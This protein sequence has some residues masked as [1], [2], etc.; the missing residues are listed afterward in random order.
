MLRFIA[1]VLALCFVATVMS[2]TN[3]EAHYKKH[4]HTKHHHTKH[5][6]KYDK[7][8]HHKWKRHFFR[9]WHRRASCAYAQKYRLQ[10]I[11][12]SDN[13]SSFQDPN[14]LE[15]KILGYSTIVDG[16][17][18]LA[19][20]E[21]I[22]SMH[23]TAGD[24]TLPGPFYQ[25]S[26]EVEEFGQVG[27]GDIAMFGAMGLKANG[28][29]NHEFDGGINQFAHMLAAAQYPFVTVNLDFSNV[30]LEDGTPA[31]RT[32]RDAR[33]CD[34]NSA[35]I[36]K[37]CWLKMGHSKVGLIGRAPADFFN[38]IADPV[39]TLPGLDFVGGRNPDTNQP[40]VSAVGQVLEQVRKLERQGIKRIILL[41]HAQDFTNDPLST[42]AL[43]GIDIIVAAG[44]TG[45]YANEPAHGP[46]NFLRPEDARTPE[47]PPY[48]VMREDSEGK[49]VLVINTEQLYRYVGHLIVTFDRRG[50]ISAIDEDR[51]GPV[52]TTPQAAGLLELEVH[53]SVN[54]EPRV[55]EV[56]EKL[57]QTPT[58]Q[59]AFEFVGT[60]AYELNGQRVDV[61][62]RETNL[63]R[64][65]ADSTL[66]YTRQTFP[67]L[68]V[69]V[70]LKNGGGIRDTILGPNIIR[71]TIQ[72]ALA[73][74]N[75]LTF[76]RMTGGQVLAA[77]ENSVSRVPAADGRFPQIAGMTLRYD[78]SFPGIEGQPSLTAASRV[79][80]LTVT[81][82]NGDVVA[83]VSGG[84]VNAAALSANFVLATNSFTSTGGDGYAA[85]A[86]AT[87]LETTNTGEQQIL[88]AYIQNALG[89]A[90]SLDDPP[91]DPRVED[92]NPQAGL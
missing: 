37:S 40:L 76:L 31:I 89:G 80:D 83:L 16:L 13:E 24:H 28:I 32:G 85:F 64:L 33:P 72:A 27:L 53:R 22:P 38:V 21:C 86:A 39:N 66:W 15:E 68:N 50:V 78:S 23:V 30:V 62:G 36:V 79:R 81:R 14:T 75:D 44:G 42:S 35:K 9:K 29:G 10:V 55:A 56:F 34:F 19:K 90:V 52:A 20:Q 3:A 57:Q 25:A 41:D 67:S 58:I 88:E 7:G 47:D 69:D 71:L 48:P 43:R 92:L 74:D 12:S 77:M 2:P 49:P 4:H 17:Q 6:H 63:G 5:H 51:S 18:K 59:S 26:A 73:F 61:R 84:V 91:A 87:P 1:G 82:A 70:A 60:T 45:F 11:H 65:A 46:F 54:A 8:L